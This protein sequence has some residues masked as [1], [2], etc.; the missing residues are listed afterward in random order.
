MA[1]QITIELPFDSDELAAL[2]TAC[3]ALGTPL[4][5]YLMD[6][7]RGAVDAQK[8]RYAHHQ[9]RMAAMQAFAPKLTIKDSK[10]APITIPGGG[11]Q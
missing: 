11:P 5:Q 6:S 10:G 4:T 7:L 3:E 9:A 1:E 2:E 8:I